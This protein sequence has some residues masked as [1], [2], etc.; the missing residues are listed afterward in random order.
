MIQFHGSPTKRALRM[1]SLRTTAWQ[2][3]KC[4]M[5]G[6]V[7]GRVSLSGEEKIPPGMTMMILPAG[8]DHPCTAYAAL[9]YVIVP[10][11]I[12]HVFK[13][14]FKFIIYGTRVGYTTYNRQQYTVCYKCKMYNAC[15]T[16]C[17]A[18]TLPS[19]AF[20]HDSKRFNSVPG[21]DMGRTDL[22]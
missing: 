11:L 9:S 3:V 18:F 20:M 6:V 19:F 12:F 21:R 7:V 1:R 22:L 17:S 5:C 16:T 10:P 2:Q 4:K 8:N 14:K 13:S 15:I